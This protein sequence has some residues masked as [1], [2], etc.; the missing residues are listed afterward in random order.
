MNP[1]RRFTTA[2]LVALLYTS[3]A[4]PSARAVTIDMVTVGNAGNAADTTTYGGVAYDYQIGKYD[5]TIG[6]YTAFLNAVAATDTYS[7]Y[8]TSMGTN[9]NVAGISRTGSSGSYTYSVINNGGDSSN[10]PIT[11]VSWWDS[12]RFSNWMANGQPTGAQSSTTTENGAYNV[13][14]VTSGSAPGRNT[15]N[16]N[17]SA[18]PTFYI[19]TENEWYKAAYYS[20][21]K[22]G[23]GSPGYYAYATQSDTAPGN[24]IGSGA[25]QAN[26]YAGD[27]AVTQS[28]S[29]SAS[30]NYLTDVGAFTNSESFYGTFDQS[31]NVYQWN[32]LDGLAPSGSSRGLRGGSW[33]YSVA[34]YLSSSDSNSAAPSDESNNIGFRRASPV[35]VPEPSTLVMGLAG[36]ACGGWQMIRRRR[37]R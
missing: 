32:D 13:N 34:F 11:Y 8:N 31:G 9:L 26:Y 23:V 16:P 21:V 35:A 27:F 12:A 37:A 17:T 4:V 18:A 5:V 19:P 7:L 30:Q 10:R 22:G 29:Y 2:A 36:I 14:G 6:Q 25:N 3:L 20:P 33:D 1:L 24:T 15:V 28:S